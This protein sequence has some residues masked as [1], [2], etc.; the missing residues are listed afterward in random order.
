MS[1]RQIYRRLENPDFRARYDKARHDLLD[2]ATAS[3]QGY[4]S[5]AVEAMHEVMQDPKTPPQ[6]R[7]NAADTIARNTLKLTEQGDI[8]ARLDALEKAQQ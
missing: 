8:L 4:L 6:T 1:E 5:A 3:L 2:K 7:L